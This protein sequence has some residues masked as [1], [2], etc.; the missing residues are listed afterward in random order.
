MFASH[1]LDNGVHLTSSATTVSIPLQLPNRGCG[2]PAAIDLSSATG[3]SSL[4]ITISSPGPR[5][6]MSSDNF[7]WASSRLMLGNMTARL[8]IN[9]LRGDAGVPASSYVN[10]FGRS[11]LK[12]DTYASSWRKVLRNNSWFAIAQC[13]T[14]LRIQVVERHVGVRLTGQHQERMLILLRTAS[15]PFG[16]VLYDKDNR[17]HVLGL[18][19]FVRV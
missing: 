18:A 1:G 19:A 14:D 7:A 11:V 10:V 13:L 6:P 5:L 17:P 9:I 12:K 2:F 3:W 16:G 4:V 8:W 15:R